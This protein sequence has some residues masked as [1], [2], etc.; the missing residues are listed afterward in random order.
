MI[1]QLGNSKVELRVARITF[2]AEGLIQNSFI[3]GKNHYFTLI[4]KVPRIA[5]LHK[6]PL[7]SRRTRGSITKH[8]HIRRHVETTIR[9]N[10]GSWL[11]LMCHRTTQGPI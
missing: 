10:H 6:S 11:E 2:V 3:V 7:S 9:W 8:G 1:H 4:G 5:L